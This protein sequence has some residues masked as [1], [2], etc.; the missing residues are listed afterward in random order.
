MNKAHLFALTLVGAA[1]PLTGN[2]VRADDAAR[3]VEARTRCSTASKRAIQRSSWNAL[4]WQFTKENTT[5]PEL[6]FRMAGSHTTTSLPS[7][8]GSRMLVH[9]PPRAR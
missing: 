1:L 2:P 5:A 9:A 6:C 3:V 8:S 7:C 4:V